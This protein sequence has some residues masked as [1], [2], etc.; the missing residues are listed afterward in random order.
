MLG[1]SFQSESATVYLCIL[2]YVSAAHMQW[3]QKPFFYIFDN[4][5][6]ILLFQSTSTC[7]E[8]FAGD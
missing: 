7:A 4:L 6:C 1:F 3:L 8:S 2:L 5:Y